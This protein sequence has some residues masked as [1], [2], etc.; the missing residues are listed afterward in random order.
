MTSAIQYR[1]RKDI[2]IVKWD[3]C[4]AEADNRL[5]YAHSWYLDYMAD[6]WDALVLNDYEAVMPL[7][8]RKKYGFKYLYQPSFCQQSGIFGKK[9]GYRKYMHEFISESKRNFRFIEIYLNFENFFTG[10]TAKNNFILPLNK[11]YEE[12]YRNFKPV[13]KQDILHAQKA[14]LNYNILSDYSH[15]VALYKT[16]Y[17]ERFRHVTD[18]DYNKFLNLCNYLNKQGKLILRSSSLNNRLKAASLLL[19][20]GE[21]LY[22]IIS[23]TL[24]EGRKLHANHYLLN[25]V[26]REFANRREVMDFEGSDLPGVAHFYTSFGCINQSYYYLRYNNLPLLIKWL[27]Q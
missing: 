21:R 11:S 6:N 8:W 13:L 19:D 1:K 10:T 16:T 9:E 22:L 15:I 27:K 24:P 26:I 14:D 25:E 20:T 2:D 12:L 5:I 7:T 18:T 23:V 3:K 17:G 4:I